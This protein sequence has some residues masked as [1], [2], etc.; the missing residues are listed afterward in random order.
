MVPENKFQVLLDLMESQKQCYHGQGSVS[1]DECQGNGTNLPFRHI[2]C[3]LTL[4]P[5]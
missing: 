3:T 5:L 1:A 2:Y 4:K